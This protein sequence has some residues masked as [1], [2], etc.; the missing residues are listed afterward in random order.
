ML[1][2]P[3]KPNDILTEREVAFNDSSPIHLSTDKYNELINRESAEEIE[4]AHAEEIKE[5]SRQEKERP[6]VAPTTT[7]RKALL[8]ILFSKFP[9]SASFIR[10]VM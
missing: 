1:R 2:A 5:K 10:G 7:T 4:E 6:R 9:T 3:E 8:K